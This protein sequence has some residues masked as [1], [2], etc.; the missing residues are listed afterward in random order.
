MTNNTK[1]QKIP[2]YRQIM[3]IIFAVA[4]LGTIFTQMNTLNLEQPPAEQFLSLDLK[5][6][7]SQ[8]S[9]VYNLDDLGEIAAFFDEQVP[10]QLEQ[11]NIVGATVAVV[12][13][14]ETIFTSSYG[15][16]NRTS[17]QAVDPNAT[18]FRVGSIS[19]LFTWTAIMQLYE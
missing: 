14:N 11:A 2:H 8:P 13:G 3:L 15:Y 12:R 7:N 17:F 4:I 16:A 9:T 10:A 6:S 19:K 1:N 18:L 5:I